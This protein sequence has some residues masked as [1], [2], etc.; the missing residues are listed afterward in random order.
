[1]KKWLKFFFFGFFSDKYSKDGAKRGYSN[2]FLAL[3]LTFAFLWLGYVGADMLPFSTWY[4]QSPDF[5]ATVHSVF[6][7]SDINKRIDAE[8]VDGTLIVKKDDE[9]IEDILIN[10][11]ENEKDKQ[12]YSVNGYNV[13]LDTRPA[14]TLAEIEAYCI[15]N[16]GE[17]TEISYEDYLTL[18]NVA[19]L[20]FDFKLRYTGEALELTDDLV[21]SYRVYVEGLN[22]ANKLETQ[23]LANDLAQGKISKGEYNRAIYELYFAS[24]Y[25]AIDEYE[26][27][28]KVPLFLAR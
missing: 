21:S 15:S 5:K 19:K 9:Y 13:I 1:M 27:S 11:F 25:P 7:N 2:V 20:N 3:L 22:E 28:S 14:D 26:S 6:A 10:T 12:N 4:D 24:Y 16:D 17:N 8:I 18:S 23:T